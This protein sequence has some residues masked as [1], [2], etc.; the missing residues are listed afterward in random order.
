MH[1]KNSLRH[2]KLNNI[3]KAKINKKNNIEKVMQPIILNFSNSNLNDSHMLALVGLVKVIIASNENRNFVVQLDHNNITSRCYAD[4]T[5]LL[6]LNVVK[7]VCICEC[8]IASGSIKNYV[9]ALSIE[10][11]Q[12]LIFVN[13]CNVHSGGWKY[14][15]KNTAKQEIIVKTH[16]E[17][18]SQKTSCSNNVIAITL[19]TMVRLHSKKRYHYCKN[20][21][22][23][24]VGDSQSSDEEDNNENENQY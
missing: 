15:I 14:L 11:L 22:H 17:M 4:I 9:I 20:C 19:G 24:C 10:H 23:C 12:K 5:E 18:Y 8:P 13:V 7:N 2:E 21:D 6:K 1:K 16:E 3:P